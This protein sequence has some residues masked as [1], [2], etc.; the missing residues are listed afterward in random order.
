MTT[1][2]D[3]TPTRDL[4]QEFSARLSLTPQTTLA[5]RLDGAWWPYSRDL[6][7]ELPPLAAALDEAAISRGIRDAPSRENAWETEG[8]ACMSPFEHLPGRRALPVPGN[9]WR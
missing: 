9:T 6:D 5:G 2:L 3:R 8:G 7:I 4:A 1:T